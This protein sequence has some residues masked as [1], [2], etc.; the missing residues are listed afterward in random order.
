VG[1]TAEGPLNQTTKHFPNTGI[2]RL[3]PQRPFNEVNGQVVNNINEMYKQN[4][5]MTPDDIG[6]HSFT[7]EHNQSLNIS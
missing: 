2:E 7:P 1:K 6:I 4:G 3:G 5:R